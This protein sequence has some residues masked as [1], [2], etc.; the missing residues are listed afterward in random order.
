MKFLAFAI[1]VYCI[2]ALLLYVNQRKIIFPGTG[3]PAPKLPQ[4]DLD[5]EQIWVETD[6]GKVE[7]WYFKA[8][9]TVSGKSGA[10][11][12]FAHGNYELIDENF[13]LA[14]A[15]NTMGVSV[16]M[17]EFPGYG[18]S[19]GKPSKKT[20]QE[21]FCKAY[22]WLVEQ[23]DVDPHKIIG[24]GRSVG[25]GPICALATDREL[26]SLILQSTFAEL[27]RF[28]HRYLLPGFIVKDTFD[29]LS[30]VR[31]FRKP[32]LIFHGRYDNVIPYS[33]SEDL[34]ENALGS[35]FISYNCGHND[36]PPDWVKYWQDIKIFLKKNN[37]IGTH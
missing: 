1:I 32:L 22:D 17:L 4:I 26:A 19:G 6:W 28:A 20:L 5:F 36:F 7:G 34:H 23:K 15:Y 11:V 30:V 18:R 21:V 10:T 31:N 37:L 25:G 9:D 27:T 14:E 12:I 16:L 35:D 3:I 29:N 13:Y 2:Y 8:G 33:N 24:H